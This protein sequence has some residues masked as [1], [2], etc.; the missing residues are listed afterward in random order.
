VSGKEQFSISGNPATLSAPYS[1]HH[2]ILL[3]PFIA[4][5]DTRYARPVVAAAR[6]SA[7][8]GQTAADSKGS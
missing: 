5:D 2:V 8:G 6:P 3:Q 7:S 4:S 1:L